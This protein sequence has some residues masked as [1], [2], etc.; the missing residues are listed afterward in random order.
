MATISDIRFE[1]SDTS[2]E[3]PILSDAEITYYLTKNSSN[4]AR[5]SMD[6]ARAILMKLSMRS[7]SVVD[8]F[9]MKSSTASRSY[10]QALQLYIKDPNLN[11]LMQNLQG[12][13][14]GVSISDMQ[15]NDSNSD[16]NRVIRPSE[17]G[18][19]LP[20]DFFG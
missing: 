19:S 20:L 10:I 7:D 2:P 15:A 13:A 4:L 3:F 16:N 17:S 14:G 8:V 9:S 5:T 11:P 18:C 6:C 12:Y 1:L